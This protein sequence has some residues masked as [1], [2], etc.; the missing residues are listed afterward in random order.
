[1]KPLR[2]RTRPPDPDPTPLPGEDELPFDFGPNLESEQHRTTMND[3]VSSLQAWL[4]DHGITDTYVGANMA[5]YFS[6]SQILN[7]DFLGPD[8]FVVKDTSLRRRKSWVV[9]QE[10]RTPCVVVEL[11]SGSTEDRDRGAKMLTYAKTLHVAEYYLF[12]PLDGRLEGYRL[13]PRHLTYVVI[14]PDDDECVDC[15]QLGLRLGVK[16]VP[17]GDEYSE[18]LLRWR[19]PDGTWVPSPDERAEAERARAE[20]QRARAEEQRARAEEA[21]AHAEAVDRRASLLAERLRALGVDPDS[22]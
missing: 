19:E 16:W 9:W 7:N 1:M 11:L 8:V 12:D 5:I 22:L 6:A 4:R 18:P 13:D 3:L 20:E 10:H 2:Q 15:T 17:D 21:E 14:R